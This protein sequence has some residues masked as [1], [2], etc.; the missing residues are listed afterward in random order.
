MLLQ[1]TTLWTE[2]I[3]ANS[4]Q[5]AV[6]PQS[7]CIKNKKKKNQPNNQTQSEVLLLGWTPDFFGEHFQWRKRRF[8]EGSLT[9]SPHTYSTNYLFPWVQPT[10]SVK[11]NKD[12][13]LDFPLW[14]LSLVGYRGTTTAFTSV[15]IF[16]KGT[17]FST[18]MFGWKSSWIQARLLNSFR[19]AFGAWAICRGEEGVGIII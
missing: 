8:W 16:W 6:K 1:G 7:N 2:R 4:F 3:C 10:L 15:F 17:T 5:A 18:F 9:A 19:P 12:L 14:A 11:K 13:D